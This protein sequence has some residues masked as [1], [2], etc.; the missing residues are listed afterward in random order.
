MKTKFDQGWKF[1]LF[2]TF[3][4]FFAIPLL[5][6]TSSGS[7]QN[8]G[9]GTTNPTEKLQVD[10]TVYSSLEGFKFPD[11]SVQTRAY[12]AYETQDAAEG[13]FF[14]V[15]DIP[16]I[17]GSF[18]FGT[19]LDDIKVIGLDWGVFYN[20][21]EVTGGPPGQCHFNLL[22]ITKEIDK[23]SPTLFQFWINGGP[24][25]S[26]VLYFYKTDSTEYYRIELQHS[27][28]VKLSERVVFNG[29]NC[30]GHLEEVVLTYSDI[31]LYWYGPPIDQFHAGPINCQTK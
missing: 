18:S 17:D 19:H 28:I 24:M 29:N 1:S 3:R 15:M 6:F 25:L 23:A 20:I 9:I 26:P 30:Y 2:T 7:A 16:G 10:G 8:I 13:R 5:W 12:N 22:T 14:V 11:G 31:K 4:A 21:S 27:I